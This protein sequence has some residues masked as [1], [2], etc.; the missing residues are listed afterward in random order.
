M[1][2]SRLPAVSRGCLCTL[3]LCVIGV[4][5]VVLLLYGP[6]SK[7]SQG[8]SLISQGASSTPS[9]TP[10]P[11]PSHTPEP[12]LPAGSYEMV[13][14]GIASTLMEDH[15]YVLHSFCQY[16]PTSC[17]VVYR[18]V[19]AVAPVMRAMFCWSGAYYVC[20]C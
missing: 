2:A 14:E 6:G 3:L 8:S 9:A 5:G 11:S 10:Q 7:Y 15:L 19:L 1:H 20:A 16:C 4:L 13:I 17:R 18:R 12:L